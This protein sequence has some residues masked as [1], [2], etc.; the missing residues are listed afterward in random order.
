KKAR[1][2]HAAHLSPS[3]VVGVLYD[4]TAFGSAEEGV[5]LTTRRLCWK[6]LTH[7]PAHLEWHRIEPETISPSGNLVYIARPGLQFTPRAELCVPMA[8]LLVALVTG[9]RSGAT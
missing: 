2:A 4:D 8:E 9:L 6:S 7:G 3:E 5:L 1:A